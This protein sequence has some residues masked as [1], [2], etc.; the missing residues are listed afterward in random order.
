MTI[1][2]MRVRVLG[3]L[4][5]SLLLLAGCAREPAPVRFHADGY[6]PKLS[7]WGVV[8]GDG[9]RLVLN[10]GVVPFDLNTPLFSDYAH[11]LRT[12][13]MP[14]GKAAKY[15]PEEAFDFPVGTILSKTFFYPRAAGGG[16]AVARTYD[17]SRD[18]DGQ[19]LNLRNVRM[20]ETRL[21]VRRA[22]GWVAL[23][24]VWNREQT[25]AELMRTG[26]SVA[27]QL[28]A[29]DGSREDFTYQVPDQNQCAGCH[30]SNN[31]T[32]LIQPL[33]PK[34]RHLNRDYA[35]D[36]G[37]ENQLAHWSRLGYLAGVPGQGV[38]R[39][40]NWRD[41]A[42]DSL[43]ARARA[44]LDVNC[45]HCHNA[46]GPADTS[47]LLLEIGSRD[48]RHLGLC[49]PPVAAGRGTGDRRYGIVPGKP[50]QSI[51]VYRM[52]SDDPGVMMPE[53]GRDV[54]HREGVELIKEWIAAMEAGGCEDKS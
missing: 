54:V 37:A 5:L 39:N 42:H 47:G 46:H 20:V 28:V 30:A 34:A 31:T 50:D 12:V 24:Y 10:K 3:W 41:A 22:S 29:E 11:K 38:P 49:K 17:E 33:G 6:P 53:L 52:D 4:A 23:A 18:R 27:L 7:D 44:Y 2:S 40:A 25:E 9:K 35:Y 32:R 13:W 15:R 36:G 26:D 8:S 1:G 45:A 21:L 19:G 14:G 16:D 48:P 51:M 43:E